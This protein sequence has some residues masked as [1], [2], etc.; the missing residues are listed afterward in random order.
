MNEQNMR[1]IHGYLRQIVNLH[2]FM[3]RPYEEARVYLTSFKLQFCAYARILL[4]ICA[5]FLTL[6]CKTL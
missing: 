3:T 2:F 5:L 4:P 1:L 6:A